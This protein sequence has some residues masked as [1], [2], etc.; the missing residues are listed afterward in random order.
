MNSFFGWQGGKMRLRNVI[1]DSFPPH[2]EKYLE[3]FGGAAWVL[4][5][6]EPGGM[7]IYN[8]QNSNLTN[9]FQCVR[10]TPLELIETLRFALSSRDDFNHI[11]EKFRSGADCEIPDGAWCPFS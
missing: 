1:V 10:E 4:F 9:L 8:D 2:F 11:L 7:E 5:H 3:V 6:K